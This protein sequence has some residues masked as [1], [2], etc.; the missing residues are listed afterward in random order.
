MTDNDHPVFLT[1]EGKR[2]RE[3][4]LEYLRTVRR[5]EVAEK[6]R[7]AKDGGDLT[8]N[9]GYDAAKEEQSHLEGRIQE[10]EALLAHAV[11]IE[12][13]NNHTMV[14]VGCHVTV[15]EHGCNPEVFHVVG[16]AETNPEEGRISHESPLG[17]ALM[18][19]K[20]GEEVEVSAPDGLIRFR[21]LEVQ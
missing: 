3:E 19:K 5:A 13:N 12:E 10:L 15:A 6:I 11:V 1:P 21:I 7:T 4:E 16:P 14:E 20:P 2:E 9:A 8:E 17:K 18:G